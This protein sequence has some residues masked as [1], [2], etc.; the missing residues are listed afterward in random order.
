MPMAAMHWRWVAYDIQGPLVATPH[1]FTTCHIMPFPLI[2]ILPE[3][4]C[5]T[6]FVFL[7]GAFVVVSYIVSIVFM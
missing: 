3:K 2:S 1:L 7:F 6:T 5:T 4:K